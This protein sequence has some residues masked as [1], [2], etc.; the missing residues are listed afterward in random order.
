[1]YCKKMNDFSPAWRAVRKWK[2][3]GIF[4]ELDDNGELV[5]INC[6]CGEDPMD[7][8][9]DAV[10]ELGEYFNE[11]KNDLYYWKRQREKINR[12][13]DGFGLNDWDLQTADCYFPDR[14]RQLKEL[15]ALMDSSPDDSPD[16]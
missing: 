9:D 3:R 1:M 11:I 14:K 7:V 16:D 13:R 5:L 10:L 2:D 4:P 12:I 15:K 8:P 6:Q